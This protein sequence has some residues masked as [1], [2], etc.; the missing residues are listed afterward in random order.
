MALHLTASAI[1]QGL[2]GVYNIKPERFGGDTSLL[3]S[4]APPVFPICFA[5]LEPAAFGRLVDNY[6]SMIA[7]VGEEQDVKAELF[8]EWT[9]LRDLITLGKV[10][11]AKLREHCQKAKT[12]VEAWTSPTWSFNRLQQFAAGLATIRPHTASI[13][14]LFSF[15]RRVRTDARTSL[16]QLTL[17]GAMQAAQLNWLQTLVAEVRRPCATNNGVT[18]PSSS[19]SSV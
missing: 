3:E 14:R 11:A 9:Q 10:T 1:L 13:E 16:Q 4:V 7:G 2:Q 17:A 8:S 12:F 6:I 15:A 18:I 5:E 19:S